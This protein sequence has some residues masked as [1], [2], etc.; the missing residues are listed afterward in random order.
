MK[1]FNILLGIWSQAGAFCIFTFLFVLS[2][3]QCLWVCYPLLAA[4]THAECFDFPLELEVLI[5]IVRIP[6]R[7]YDGLVRIDVKGNQRICGLVYVSVN[8]SFFAVWWWNLSSVRSLDFLEL[9]D[10]SHVS[11]KMFRWCCFHFSIEFLLDSWCFLFGF[12]PVSVVWYCVE[13]SGILLWH[14]C[15]FVRALLDGAV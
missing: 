13:Y 2:P 9:P 5:L 1:R 14:L 11:L 10:L 6:S 8:D 7:L 12:S 3:L 15:G 4:G